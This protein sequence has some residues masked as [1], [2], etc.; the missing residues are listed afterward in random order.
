[1]RTSSFNVETMKTY[2]HRVVGLYPTRGMADAAHRGMVDCGIPLQQIQILAPGADLSGAIGRSDSDDVLKDLLRDGAIGAAVG[3][4]TGAVAAMVM[5]AADVSLFSA[6]PVFSAFYLL[7]WG[8]SFG[9]LT[10]AIIGSERSKGDVS[11]LIK[12]AL[13]SGQFVMVAYTLTESQ[14]SQAQQV[15]NLHLEAVEK[16]TSREPGNRTAVGF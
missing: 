11:H 9:A 5:A 10:G 15:I 3:I 12:E 7:G 8:A 14:T 6:N 16:V 2:L 4:S 1:M 13:E